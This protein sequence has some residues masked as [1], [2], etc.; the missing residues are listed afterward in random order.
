[1]TIQNWYVCID[2]IEKIGKYELSVLLT[3]METGKLIV[4]KKTMSVNRIQ[5]LTIFA[6]CNNK[7]RLA[8]EILSRFLKFH[9]Q[10]YKYPE[11]VLITKNVATK[12]FKR[13][14]EFGEAVANSVWNDMWSR[15]VRDCIKIMKLAKK[16]DDIIMIIEAIQ[17][18]R[19]N[20]KE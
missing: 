14:T 9:L 13:T 10:P 15:D 6:T 16:E 3:L 1:M 17:Q 20:K 4:Q 18:Y 7:Y 11:F 2:E 12:K 19:E 8:P 5:N